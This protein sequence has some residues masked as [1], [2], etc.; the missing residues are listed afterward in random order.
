MKYGLC[1]GRLD[2]GGG[3]GGMKTEKEEERYLCV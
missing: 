2:G 3:E 1:V